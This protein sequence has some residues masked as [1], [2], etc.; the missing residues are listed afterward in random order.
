MSMQKSS[1]DVLSE[2]EKD[3]VSTIEEVEF[4]RL[5][6]KNLVMRVSSPGKPDQTPGDAGNSGKFIWK[7]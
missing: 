2:T 3:E 1:K 6:G 7:V 4:G 5:Q